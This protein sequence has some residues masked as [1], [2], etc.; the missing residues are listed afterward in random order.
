MIMDR[1]GDE[2]LGLIAD[3]PLRRLDLWR[4]V[5]HAAGHRIDQIMRCL[6]GQSSS[7]RVMP[8]PWELDLENEDDPGC[9]M[10]QS[11]RRSS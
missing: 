1:R 10:L 5:D 2:V 4:F 7:R 3:P 9:C 8:R 11:S 6:G